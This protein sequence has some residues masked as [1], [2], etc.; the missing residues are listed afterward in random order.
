MKT[1]C[2]Y[3]YKV[4][5]FYSDRREINIYLYVYIDFLFV[6]Y[7][8]NDLCFGNCRHN[9]VRSVYLPNQVSFFFCDNNRV[10]LSA[11]YLCC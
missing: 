5:F 9:L 11:F 6:V 1:H 2:M 4:F 3:I 8:S 10:T 7:I